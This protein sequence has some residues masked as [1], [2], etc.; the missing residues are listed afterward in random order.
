MRTRSYAQ[1]FNREYCFYCQEVKYET[2]KRVEELYECRSSNIGKSIQEV[3]K[4]SDNKVWK[5]HLADIIAEGDFLSR[6]VKY[7]KSCHTTHWRCYV[8]GPNRLSKDKNN[9][10]LKTVEFISAEI[11]YLAEIEERLDDGEFL[12]VKETVT[13]YSRMM[14]DHGV[15]G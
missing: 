9:M 4:A 11:E 6:D 1:V 3:V 12:T 5:V 8:Q 2:K 10:E 14:H 13:L 15:E 7:H